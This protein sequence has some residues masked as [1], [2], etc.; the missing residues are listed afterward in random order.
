MPTGHVYFLRSGN[1]VKIGFSTNLR[2]RQR[3]IQTACSEPAFICR[4]IEGDMDT[5]RA[6]HKRF[7]EYRLKGEWFDLRGAVA[8]YLERHIWPIELPGP[9][10]EPEDDD[11]RL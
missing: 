6:F 4:V 9:M 11:I 5:E 2:E 7:A 1:A 10:P 3:S 8:R